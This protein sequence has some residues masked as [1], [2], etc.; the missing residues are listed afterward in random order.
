MLKFSGRAGFFSLFFISFGRIAF[1]KRKLVQHFPVHFAA[2]HQ[3]EDS[4][5]DEARSNGVTQKMAADD[6]AARGHG[7]NI[8]GTQD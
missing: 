2:A 7:S 3:K 1:S 8:D 6:N 5:H 4:R